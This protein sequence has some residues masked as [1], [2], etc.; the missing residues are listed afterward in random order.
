MTEP[1]VDFD[2]N[3]KRSHTGDNL[4]NE[5][6][7]KKICNRDD[8]SSHVSVLTLAAKKAKQCAESFSSDQSESYFSDSDDDDDYMGRDV[9]KTVTPNLSINKFI[10]ALTDNTT[11]D[12][13][14]SSSS[15]KFKKYYCPCAGNMAEWRIKS[16]LCIDEDS[17]CKNKTF[18]SMNALKDHCHSNGDNYHK[19]VIAFINNM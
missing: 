13:S 16:G 2:T 4:S 5:L 18:R 3:K 10:D 14:S 15:S 9:I 6:G 1:S 7:R 19:A 11:F 17:V 12:V 8:D